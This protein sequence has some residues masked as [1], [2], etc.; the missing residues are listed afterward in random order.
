[1]LKLVHDR[2]DLPPSWDGVLV[3]WSEWSEGRT[4]LIH[5]A[6]P[7]SLACAECGTVD[8]PII[9]FGKRPPADGVTFTTDKTRHTKSGRA[10]TWGTEEVPAWPVNDLIAARCRHCAHDVV[11][12]RRTGERWDLDE[13]D[14][15]PD[16]SINTDTLF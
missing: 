4:T 3:E 1:M 13:T 11:T 6:P 16:G 5:H 15:G 10:Y 2:R 9:S 7:E 12:D 8:E 14:Y